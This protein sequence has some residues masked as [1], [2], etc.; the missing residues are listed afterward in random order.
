MIFAEPSGPFGPVTPFLEQ[1]CVRGV[2]TNCLQEYFA[3]DSEYH[4]DVSL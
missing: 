3:I 4:K 2:P 1:V